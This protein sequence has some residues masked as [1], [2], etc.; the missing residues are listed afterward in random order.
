[1][2]QRHDGS[3]CGFKNGIFPCLM[4]GNEERKAQHTDSDE[5][6]IDWR[7][8]LEVFRIRR[9]LLRVGGSKDEREASHGRED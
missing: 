4:G 2:K 9:L 3:V 5:E 6:G 8:S 7:V 1:M